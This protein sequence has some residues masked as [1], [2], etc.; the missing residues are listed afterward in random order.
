[1]MKGYV[2]LENCEEDSG[3]VEGGLEAKRTSSWFSKLK[4]SRK[5]VV[6]EHK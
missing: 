1:M 5:N 4:I 2:S 6:T 3:N